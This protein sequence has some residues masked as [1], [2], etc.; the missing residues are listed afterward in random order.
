MKVRTS[1]SSIA[2]RYVK[3]DLDCFD[4]AQEETKQIGKINSVNKRKTMDR[5]SVPKVNVKLFKITASY[6]TKNWK[7]TIDWLKFRQLSTPK[8]NAPRETSKHH[9]RIKALAVLCGAKM[10]T[11]TPTMSKI[12]IAKIGKLKKG[13]ILFSASSV[14]SQE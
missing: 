4:T 7:P 11:K 8:A 5:P 2:S 1:K 13:D 3:K 6:F 10:Q 9:K 14:N 12:I